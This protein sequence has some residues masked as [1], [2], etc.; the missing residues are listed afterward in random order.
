M[1]PKQ[2]FLSSKLNAELSPGGSKWNYRH[3]AKTF[4]GINCNFKL[5]SAHAETAVNITEATDGK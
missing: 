1:C 2:I 5:T 3:A 4:H